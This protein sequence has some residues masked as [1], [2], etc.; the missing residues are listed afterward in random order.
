MTSRDLLVKLFASA[1]DAARGDKVLRTSTHVRGDAF[2]Y[3]GEGGSLEIPLPA[4]S[5]RVI[6]AGAGKAAASLASGLQY[7]L[8]DR[9]GEGKVI[10]KH[11][12]GAPLERI[13]VL[14]ASHPVP[15]E[16]S[17]AATQS[18]LRLIDGT[19]E[20]DV[21]FFLLTGGASSLLCLPVEGLSLADKAAATTLLLNS[22]ADIHEMNTVRKHLSAV[23]GGRLRLRSRAKAF[24][25]LTISDVIGDDPAVIGSGPTVADRSSALD[26]LSIVARYELES[27]M[28]MSVIEHLRTDATSGAAQWPFPQDVYRIVA[29]NRASLDACV[30]SAGARQLDVSVLPD[31]MVGDTA[32]AARAFAEKLKELAKLSR[33]RPHIVITGGETT[34]KVKGSGKGGRNQ[35]FA[36]HAAF[37]VD[38]VRNVTLLAAGTDGT[39]G[40]TD[41][42]GAFADGSTVAR[43]RAAGLEIDAYLRRNDAYPLL[44]ALG[45]LFKTGPTGTNVMD[46]AIGIVG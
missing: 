37:A 29:S 11:G 26:A 6:V 10:V 8:G 13:A 45:D 12:H 18:L 2:V 38:G 19:K 20:Q 24:C 31:P 7:A 17:V 5:G 44:D 34:L 35:E 1:V 42:A 28:P 32:T 27:R 23:K 43:A 25:T 14:E 39:D 30:R 36:L 16:S 22:G 4:G 33:A 15:D 3:E 40:P 21:V 9:I 46:L 41:V